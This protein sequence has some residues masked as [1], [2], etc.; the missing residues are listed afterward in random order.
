MF[1]P[2]L[3]LIVSAAVA[4]LVTGCSSSDDNRPTARTGWLGHLSTLERVAGTKGSN[5]GVFIHRAADAAVKV[6]TVFLSPVDVTLAAGSDLQTIEPSDIETLR[7]LFASSVRSALKDK[8]E[9]VSRPESGSYTMRVALTHVRVGRT[10]RLGGSDRRVHLRFVLSSAAIQSELRDGAT[11]KRR[12][13]TIAT[14]V[15]DK[16]QPANPVNWDEAVAKFDEYTAL[17]A[18]QLDTAFTAL[19]VP[20]PPSK[21]AKPAK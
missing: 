20:P 11:N 21:D 2:A 19:S 7:E 4:A 3:K 10:K 17:L 1:R 6:E 16:E 18:V 9:F 8:V 13:A 14:G 15:I 5:E 12:V